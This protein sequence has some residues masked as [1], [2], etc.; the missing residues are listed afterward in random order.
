CTRVSAS[1]SSVASTVLRTPVSST[2]R[3]WYQARARGGGPPGS[4]VAASG[5]RICPGDR[6]GGEEG[7]ER[8]CEG[9]R[10]VD[11]QEV[12]AAGD[13]RQGRAG[14]VAVEAAGVVDGDVG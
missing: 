9:L 2:T 4:R 10:A 12:G 7:G 11:R 13:H 3:A 5:G 14:D 8:P 1:A 6:V